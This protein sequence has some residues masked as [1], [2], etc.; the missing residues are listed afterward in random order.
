MPNKPSMT[1]EDFEDALDRFGGDLARWPKSARRAAEALLEQ[2]ARAGLLLREAQEI[3]AALAPGA[4]PQAAPELTDRIMQRVA[5]HEVA[6]QNRQ[7][8]VS[9]RR[10]GVAWLLRLLS[11]AS[12]PIPREIVA[13]GCGTAVGLLVGLA[14][15]SYWPAVQATPDLVSLSIAS[16][17]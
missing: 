17:Y 11:P 10:I 2:D 15:T 9:A 4:A 3:D 12:W 5:Q 16:Y 8:E 6:E 7:A 14:L 13:I 1:L